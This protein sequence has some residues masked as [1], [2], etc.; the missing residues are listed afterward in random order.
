M[1]ESKLFHFHL[2]AIRNPYKLLLCISNYRSTTSS[3]NISIG[4]RNRKVL[5]NLFLWAPLNVIMIASAVMRFQRC[6]VPF[7]NSSNADRC[8]SFTFYFSQGKLF[9]M[10]R[11]CRKIS[12]SAFYISISLEWENK[13][14]PVMMI[15]Y[16]GSVNR[17]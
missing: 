12:P 7:S 8:I 11:G 9:R 16:P 13:N 3:V 15:V 5:L 4:W 6:N 1:K 10:L 2:C 17:K 14:E